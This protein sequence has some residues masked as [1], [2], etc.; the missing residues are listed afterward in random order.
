M[1]VTLRSVDPIDVALVRDVQRKSNEELI[2][3][4]QLEVV[5]Q[6]LLDPEE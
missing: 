1:V 2:A 5:V 3:N 6:M 4:I